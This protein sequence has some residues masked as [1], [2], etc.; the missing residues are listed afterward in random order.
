MTVSVAVTLGV[1]RMLVLFCRTKL[2]DVKVL[3]HGS[4]VLVDGSLIHIERGS[5]CRLWCSFRVEKVA[6]VFRGMQPPGI[7]GPGLPK[8]GSMGHGLGGPLNGGAV[9]IGGNNPPMPGIRVIVAV[10]VWP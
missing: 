5:P 2:V 7:T 4:G 1:G 3:S 6:V 9:G 10:M 8:R